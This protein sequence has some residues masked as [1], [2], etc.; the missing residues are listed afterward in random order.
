MFIIGLT[1]GISSGKSTVSGYLRER[2]AAIIDAD[3]LAREL[4][5]PGQPAYR[6][7]V[8][9]FGEQIL[10]PGGRLDRIRLGQLVFANPGARQQLNQMTHPRVKQK[11][12]EILEGLTKDAAVMLAVVD[13]PLLIEASM[14]SLV[15]QVWLL[16]VDE[17]IQVS[18]LM[19]RDGMTA[20]DARRRIASQMPLAEK[21]RWADKIIDN[22][23]G[24]QETVKQVQYLLQELNITSIRDV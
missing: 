2:G 1:G 10:D 7:I 6:E 4:V 15:D 8:Q 18:R 22:N 13:A 23:G 12:S 9:F 11:T 19:E 3:Q 20:A 17:E 14:T 16:E 24:F 5:E 21:K